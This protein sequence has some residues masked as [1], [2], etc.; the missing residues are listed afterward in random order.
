MTEVAEKVQRIARLTPLAD[1]LARIDTLVAP[2]APRAVNTSEAAG[3]VLAQDVVAPAH[4]RVPLALRDGY[5]VKAE[6]TMDAGAYAPAP[7]TAASWVAVGDPLPVGADAVAPVDAVRAWDARVEALAPIAPGEGVLPAG[8]DASEAPLRRAGEVLRP[9]DQAVLTALGVARARVRA[10]RARLALARPQDRF[11]R[12]IEAMLS[13]MIISAGATAER[14]TGDVAA[15]LGSGADLVVIVGG[16]GSG[17]ED[18]SVE[19]LARLGR[20]EAHGVA[21]APGE[22]T[23]WGMAGTTAV[24]IVPGRIDA[25]LAGFL[26]IGQHVLAR[27]SGRTAEAALY[28]AALVRKISSTIGLVEVVPV[29]REGNGVVPLA[30]G[31]LPLQALTQASGYVVV[32]AE[33]EG[34]PAGA[35]VR[36]R[37][38]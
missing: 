26:L 23:A 22:T 18:R 8:A 38:L 2:V 13:A 35:E 31:Y 19:E 32:P 33:S 36:V 30:L 21:I 12:A 28:P 10:P 34:F 29:R 11:A 1:V 4:P 9:L 7:L 3:C 24:L 5:A 14:T 27:L 37:P 20:I 15:A 6:E 16:T 25:A 17:R